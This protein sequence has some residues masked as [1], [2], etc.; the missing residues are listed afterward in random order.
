MTDYALMNL[1]WLKQPLR[2]PDLP[3]RRV[4]ADCFAATQPDEQ[5]WESFVS[6]IEKL[7]RQNRITADDYYL[8]RYS[9]EAK[10]SLMDLTLGREETFKE[11]TVL[12]ILS[13]AREK[14]KRE[15]EVISQRR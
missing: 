4:V 3:W 9:I 11:G 12:D 13:R 5:L 15:F 2:A 14:V 10:T 6:E 7:E 1:L 8:L